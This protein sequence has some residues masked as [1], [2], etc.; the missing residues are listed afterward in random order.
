LELISLSNVR[1]A[2]EKLTTKALRDELAQH[3]KDCAEDKPVAQATVRCGTT[4]LKSYAPDFWGKVFLEAFARG[5]CVEK[6]G[7]DLIHPL[8]GVNWSDHLLNQ[9]DKPWFRAHKEWQAAAFK[10]FQRRNQI[11]EC[12]AMIS[13]NKKF[14]ADAE[15]MHR[16]HANDILA[17]AHEASDSATLR[18]LI[19]NSE[20][21]AHIRTCMYHVHTVMKKVM[22]TDSER[23][24]F[25]SY[26]QALR[27]YH[28]PGMLFWTLNPR[29]SNNPL[30]IRYMAEG[31]WKHHKVPLDIDDLQVHMSLEG[32]RKEN[33]VA[34]QEMILEDPVAASKCFHK[35]VHMTLE[36]LFNSTGPVYKGGL[37]SKHFLWTVSHVNSILVL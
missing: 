31:S 28:G 4:F 2:L 11:R 37:I 33:P 23:A 16:L 15:L 22:G 34:L 13:H 10:Y 27:F 21:A 24:T 32:I 5:D 18:T 3:A 35:T 20:T 17:L 1:K 30:T 29:D 36:F 9:V 12:E 8:I 19:A 6:A 7:R 26:F 14:A 25:Q